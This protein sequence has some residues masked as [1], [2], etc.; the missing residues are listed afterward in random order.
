MMSHQLT[1]DADRPRPVRNSHVDVHAA[2]P[3]PARRPLEI[4]AEV[5]AGYETAYDVVANAL[6]KHP[7]HWGLLL[8]RGTTAFDWNTF[9]QENGDA[10]EFVERRTSAFEVL[11]KAAAKYSADLPEEEEDETTEAA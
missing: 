3:H 9:S 4:L 11:E 7:D 5:E 10:S 2:D 1:D 6:K 8:A